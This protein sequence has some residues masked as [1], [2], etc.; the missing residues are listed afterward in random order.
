MRSE[1]V[2][3]RAR[4]PTYLEWLSSEQV[5]VPTQAIKWLNSIPYIYTVPNDDNRAE[6]GVEL[7][8]LYETAY[9]TEYPGESILQ[10]CSVMEMLVPAQRAEDSFGDVGFAST[11]EQWFRIMIENLGL[12]DASGLR[13]I[14]TIV[15]RMMRRGYDEYGQG[16]S[17][18]AAPAAGRSA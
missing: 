9:R 8:Y 13:E 4:P 18:S 15:M 11:R 17:L 6:E 14:K 16:W 2:K 3:G 10:P 1:P 12:V 7:R 5:Y